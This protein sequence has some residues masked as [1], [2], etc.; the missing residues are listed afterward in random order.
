MR[1]THAQYYLGHLPH[2][3]NRAWSNSFLRMNSRLFEAF[4]EMLDRVPAKA[5]VRAAEAERR[6]VED[7]IAAKRT[8]ADRD[9]TS[10]LTFCNF[11]INAARGIQCAFP[12]WPIEHCAY[13]RKVV[14]RLVEAGELP[15]GIKVKFDISF[16][17]ALVRA[18]ATP[19]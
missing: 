4:C 7:D 8:E 9:A 15:E 16:S 6:M 3:E 14:Q 2:G 10:V 5:I 11:L 17:Q 13:Y 1:N 18:L 12:L 19:G